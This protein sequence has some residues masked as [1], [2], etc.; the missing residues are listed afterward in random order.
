M[1]SRYQVVIDISPKV[2]NMRY[3]RC[4]KLYTHKKIEVHG[5]RLCGLLLKRYVELVTGG[6]HWGFVVY[7]IHG[8]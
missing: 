4:Y 5:F 1:G 7:G 8:G 6:A 3:E 2:E